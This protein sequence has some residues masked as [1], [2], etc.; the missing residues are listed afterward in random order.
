VIV[1]S[2]V[3]ARFTRGA[4][5]ANTLS[6]RRGVAVRR[7]LETLTARKAFDLETGTYKIMSVGVK[8]RSPSTHSGC[9]GIEY[10]NS[11]RHAL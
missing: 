4:T 7:P 9:A 5:L 3:P 2:R 6:A 11:P 1:T 8:T 10:A